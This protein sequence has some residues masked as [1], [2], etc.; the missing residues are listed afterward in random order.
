MRSRCFLRR[1][2]LRFRGN[3]L[4][5]GGGG[6]RGICKGKMERGEAGL[7]G[8][9]RSGRRGMRLGS[10]GGRRLVGGVMTM[11]GD[12][13]LGRS[14]GRMTVLTEWFLLKP[15]LSPLSHMYRVE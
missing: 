10:W 4:R 5:R 7:E 13:G 8:E 11:G 3:G 6:G 15:F 9:S 12:I 14:G 1:A 2:L